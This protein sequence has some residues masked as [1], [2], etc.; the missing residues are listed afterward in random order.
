MKTILLI[1]ILS[2][3]IYQAEFLNIFKEGLGIG[4]EKPS[5]QVLNK[6]GNNIEI[7][8]YSTSKWVQTS[9]TSQARS[10]PSSFMFRKLFMYISGS[11]EVKQKIEMTAPVLTQMQ[12]LSSQLINTNTQVKFTMGFYVPQKNQENTPEPMSD[13]VDIQNVP[14]TTYAVIRFGGYASMNDYLRNRD[15]LIRALGNEASQFDT[16]NMLVAGYDAPFKFFDRTNEV[17]LKKL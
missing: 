15:V 9:S 8:K 12:S 14:E 2:A 13:D 3:L 17:W 5:Y 7:R 1:T 10:M 6:I 4:I 16:I 11:N